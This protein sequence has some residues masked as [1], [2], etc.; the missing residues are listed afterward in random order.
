MYIE[1]GRAWAKLH[2]FN[3]SSPGTQLPLGKGID[4]QTL[5]SQGLPPSPCDLPSKRTPNEGAN[6]RNEALNTER[7]EGGKAEIA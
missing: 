1:L 3:S 2:C 5:E 4:T 6:E 7:V